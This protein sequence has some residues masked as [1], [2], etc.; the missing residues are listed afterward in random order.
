MKPESANGRADGRAWQQRLKKV[1]LTCQRSSA[2]GR[3]WQILIENR[4]GSVNG[5]RQTANWQFCGC[6]PK[7]DWVSAFPRIPGGLGD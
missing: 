1:G 3:R 4:T 2:S 5:C 7:N 6:A